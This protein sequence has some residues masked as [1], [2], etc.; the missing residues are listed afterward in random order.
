MTSLLGSLVYLIPAFS[1]YLSMCLPFLHSIVTSVRPGF[2]SHA[3]AWHG[4]QSQNMLTCQLL[5]F[6]CD[7]NISSRMCWKVD[8]RVEMW[9]VVELYEMGPRENF[10]CHERSH[11]QIDQG[12]SHGTLKSFGFCKSE[13]NPWII[14]DYKCDLFPKCTLLYS[15]LCCMPLGPSILDC[16]P[17]EI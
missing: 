3:R 5:W 6:G 14:R 11:P 15:L 2:W 1:M 4:A 16:G 12:S 13:L 7:L 9:K 10:L 8:L 17:P